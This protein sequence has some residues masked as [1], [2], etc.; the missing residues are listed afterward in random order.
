MVHVHNIYHTWIFVITWPP[1][2]QLCDFP[3]IIRL[4]KGCACTSRT[5]CFIYNTISKNL[6]AFAACYFTFM[7]SAILYYIWLW[8]WTQKDA[9]KFYNPML[10]IEQLMPTWSFSIPAIS[11]NFG[12]NEINAMSNATCTWFLSNCWKLS[13]L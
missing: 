3:F 11:I 8:N 6:H 9:E 1:T 2:A 12:M 13:Q 10:E 4:R 7:I 5:R